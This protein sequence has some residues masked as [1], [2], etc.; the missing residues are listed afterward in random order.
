MKVKFRDE[1]VECIRQ[2]RVATEG[3]VCVL[4]LVLVALVIGLSSKGDGSLRPAS[5]DPSPGFPKEHQAS[6][7]SRP[8]ASAGFQP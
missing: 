6:P 4:L 2:N 1:V 3:V 8:R 7:P 5:P